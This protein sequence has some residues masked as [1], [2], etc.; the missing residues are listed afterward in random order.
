M[1]A[2]EAWGLQSTENVRTML[3]EVRREPGACLPACLPPQVSGF[4]SSRYSH[5]LEAELGG[6]LRLNRRRRA[7]MGLTPAPSWNSEMLT[8]IYLFILFFFSF[9]ASGA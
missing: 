4:H 5:S 9:V 1:L 2:G 7:E 8:C 3:P 6:W